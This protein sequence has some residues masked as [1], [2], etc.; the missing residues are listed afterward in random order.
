MLILLIFFQVQAVEII[1]PIPE[2]IISPGENYYL[3]LYN[4]F[5]GDFIGFNIS[6]N[7]T[8]IDIVSNNS[9]SIS[10]NDIVYNL[11]EK[12]NYTVT[13]ILTTIEYYSNT[14]YIVISSYSLL[15]FDLR[16]PDILISECEISGDDSSF[17][18]IIKVLPLKVS[19]S[20]IQILV[21]YLSKAYNGNKESK[22]KGE[23]YYKNSFKIIDFTTWLQDNSCEKYKIINDI[24]LWDVKHAYDYFLFEIPNLVVGSSNSMLIPMVYYNYYKGEIYIYNFTDYLN[25]GLHSFL[26]FSGEA[27]EDSLVY[28]NYL[29]IITNKYKIFCYSLD[30]LYN[31]YAMTYADDWGPLL[32][33]QISLNGNSIIITTNSAFI[34]L[35]T[36]DLQR[37]YYKNITFQFLP[38][39]IH[40]IIELPEYDL[41]VQNLLGKSIL[42]IS[43]NNNYFNIIQRL[44]ISDSTNVQWAA[45]QDF[46]SDIKVI[47]VNKH[48]I[49]M[50]KFNITLANLCIDQETNSNLIIKAYDLNN[51][52]DYVE[53]PFEVSKATN[54][55]L[56]IYDNN[57]DIHYNIQCDG[58]SFIWKVNCYDLFS[59]P[60]LTCEISDIKYSDNN[61]DQITVINNRCIYNEGYKISVPYI[62][63]YMISYK[64]LVIFFNSSHAIIYS[65]ETLERVSELMPFRFTDSVEKMYVYG[66]YIYALHCCDNKNSASTLS[67]IKNI[68][69]LSPG[70]SVELYDIFDVA[71]T[72]NLTLAISHKNISG[73]SQDLLNNYFITNEIEIMAFASYNN[74]IYTLQN[75]VILIQNLLEVSYLH[76]INISNENYSYL[77]ANADYIILYNETAATLYDSSFYDEIKTLDFDKPWI[78]MSMLN[79]SIVTIEGK[80][81]NLYNFDNF[82]YNSLIGTYVLDYIPDNCTIIFNEM[83]N[84]LSVMTNSDF[85]VINYNPLGSNI[86][87][88]SSLISNV[89]LSSSILPIYVNITADAFK[90]TENDSSSLVV[91][92]DLNINGLTY[93]IMNMNSNNITLSCD[94]EYYYNLDNAI[95][96][97]NISFSTN[98]KNIDIQLSQIIENIGNY[99]YKGLQFFV[100]DNY[101]LTVSIDDNSIFINNQSIYPPPEYSYIK[102]TFI[103]LK[104]LNSFNQLLY[105]FTGSYNETYEY[106]YWRAN[107]S[108][109]LQNTEYF[110]TL[111]YYNIETEKLSHLYSKTIFVRPDKIRVVALNSKKFMLFTFNTFQSPQPNMTYKNVVYIFNSVLDPM[112]VEFTILGI[113]TI[114][115]SDIVGI[116]D[117]I[118]NH[119]YM[120]IADIN[121][122][123]RIFKVIDNLDLKK[124]GIVQLDQSIA[125]LALSYPI[126]YITTESTNVYKYIVNN[127][128]NFQFIGA[129]YAINEGF[130]PLPA[131]MILDKDYEA[132]YLAQIIYNSINSNSSNSSDNSNSSYFLQVINL[133]SPS[134]SNILT[135]YYLTNNNY[136]FSLAFQQSNNV[137]VFYNELLFKFVISPGKLSLNCSN[138]NNYKSG[139]YDY[140]VSAFN[141][142]YNVNLPFK[143]KVTKE[144]YQSGSLGNSLNL[145]IILIIAGGSIGFLIVIFLVWKKFFRRAKKKTNVS[146]GLFI[147]DFYEIEKEVLIGMIVDDKDNLSL[148]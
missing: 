145:S 99:S 127:F 53:L 37:V 22:G 52:D 31:P 137:L 140:N 133:N 30:N 63:P 122:G 144:H 139:T 2:Y 10:Q 42:Y 100:D 6:S 51:T 27:P 35:S 138:K 44:E 118:F 132:T 41:F 107:S 50:I 7:K 111:W 84:N 34:T 17:K 3:P 120:Y 57:Q 134:T 130:N 82:I 8:G 129:I 68:Y 135:E 73:Y 112:P 12:L 101:N 94:G 64:N 72:E 71:F 5:Y 143:I 86:G 4:Y 103:S 61:I 119:Y 36:P 13:S 38:G 21:F 66:D 47:I 1:Q 78:C 29:Y 148:D 48:T 76:A 18:E 114:Y 87:I 49:N 33:L 46:P 123:I 55:E 75:N 116:Y 115:V 102:M 79:N 108:L 125:S 62:L 74:F 110:I 16:S 113:N 45:F 96:G 80:N 141:Q 124:M 24:E 40:R 136:N 26:N 106:N 95:T 83:D 105:F 142:Y 43:Q 20:N 39:L 121:Y 28:D 89:S 67:I 90:G 70:Y 97:Q 23:I 60:N 88:Y 56:I 32:K 92:L 58:L 69:T 65:L 91:E 146:P 109:I 81:L 9:I 85:M 25:P 117:P 98:E 15:L 147:Y 54:K 11:T 104:Y 14:Y 126:M 128:I 131:T 93:N 59:A 77:Y 19:F